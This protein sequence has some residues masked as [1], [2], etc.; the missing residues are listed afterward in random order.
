MAKMHRR[1]FLKRIG[2]GALAFS[3]AS[4]TLAR[5]AQKARKPNVL[6]IAIDDMNDLDI[7]AA[8]DPVVL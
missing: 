2:V 3:A 4:C 7:D 6:F 5:S 1:M 8:P